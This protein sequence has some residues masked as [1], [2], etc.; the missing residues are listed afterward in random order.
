[1]LVPRWKR[2][3]QYWYPLLFC[4]THGAVIVAL[5]YRS[6]YVSERHT[7]PLVAILA[8]SAAAGLK[9]WQRLWQRLPFAKAILSWKHWP[10]TTALILV[11]SCVI[12]LMKP[13][14]ENRVGHAIAGETLK[15]ELLKL[16]PAELQSVVILDH[17]EWA[18]YHIGVLPGTRWDENLY[19]V[20]K[21][22]PEAQQRI[23]FIV[24]EEKEGEID[25]PKFDSTRHQDAVKLLRNPKFRWL[26]LGTYPDH[27]KSDA[28]VRVSLYRAESIEP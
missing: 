16:T 4:I 1:V 22:P 10:A 21:D 18:Q 8:I 24:L 15:V 5:A 28:F 9:P 2:E 14:H 23:R 3:P 17:Y 25:A 11:T 27:Q 19:R 7:I 6:G 20:P 12:G 13:L 26:K